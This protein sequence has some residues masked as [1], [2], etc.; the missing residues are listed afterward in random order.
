MLCES[1]FIG[2]KILC[3]LFPRRQ[4]HEMS[5]SFFPVKIRKLSSTEFDHSV[6]RINSESCSGE[7]NRGM[8]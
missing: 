6:F 8:S 7:I 4:L 3:R 5:K 2:F 1:L